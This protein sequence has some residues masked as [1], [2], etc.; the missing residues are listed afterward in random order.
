MHGQKT[1]T[2][3]AGEEKIDLSRE[4]LGPDVSHADL[5][6]VAAWLATAAGAGVTK[7]DIS[8]ADIDTSSQ[9]ALKTAAPEGCEVVHGRA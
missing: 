4:N 5:T 8:G 2:L 6:L 3:T 9:E 1:Y 7:I